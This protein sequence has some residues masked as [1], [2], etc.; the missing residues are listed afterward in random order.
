MLFSRNY[1]V[2][3]FKRIIGQRTFDPKSKN[4]WLQV[5]LIA[6]IAVIYG[7]SFGMFPKAHHQ[8]FTI[9]WIAHGIT[10]SGQI[11]VI[12]FF[13]LSGAV[14][15]GS[16]LCS[17]PFSFLVKRISRIL[18]ALLACLIIS[19]LFTF[20]IFPRIHTRDILKYVVLNLLNIFNVGQLPLIGGSILF[21]VPGAFN[22]NVYKALNGSLWTLP[23][24]FRLYFFI[25]LISVVSSRFSKRQFLAI[26][27]LTLFLL[28]HSP[29][30]VPW[31]GSSD[32]LLGNENAVINSIFFLIGS[33]FYI[34]EADRL[35]S[36]AQLFL[37]FLFY[38]FWLGQRETH[39]LFF[40]SIIFFVMFLAKV[41][42]LDH[43]R[44]PGDYS[45]GVY[46]YGWPAGQFLFHFFPHLIPE[47][48]FFF[49]AIIALGLAIPSW[50]FLEAVVLNTVR[51]K[52]KM[53]EKG[54][55]ND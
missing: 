43:L 16:L 40:I 51:A 37:S 28:L 17:T 39:I 52:L 3:F 33:S 27:F 2:A 4:N 24:E 26:N 23:Q 22:N 48:A 8:D 44:L 29:S 5:R 19:S 35:R 9:K 1:N 11:A 18:P 25:F 12:I 55:K 45:Y 41:A 21:N 15:S 47:Y 10:Y 30:N 32:A 14:V 53:L 36:F 49:T 38:S 50:H 13:F 34:L 54:K 7:H 6:A 31:I 42:P 20:V 46:L